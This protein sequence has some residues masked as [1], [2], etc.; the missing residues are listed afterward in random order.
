MGKL[1]FTMWFL[2]SF[3]LSLYDCGSVLL[4]FRPCHRSHGYSQACHRGGPT[5]IP[6]GICDGK[7]GTEAIFFSITSDFLCHYHSTSAPYS[8]PFTYNLSN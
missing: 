1:F 2:T 6:C 4:V 3:F 8:V 7:S 5:S